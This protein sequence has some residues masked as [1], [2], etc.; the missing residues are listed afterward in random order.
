MMILMSSKRFTGK[1]V[2]NL[3]V[4]TSVFFL[5]I[6][7]GL[8]TGCSKD[9]DDPAVIE[10]AVLIGKTD[11]NDFQENLLNILDNELV[12]GESTTIQ[13]SLA[14]NDGSPY[15]T[16]VEVFFS[17]SCASSAF[18]P[19][20]IVTN[21]GIASVQYT[22]GD[23]GGVDTIN[24][25]STING[26]N[27]VATGGITL[28]RRVNVL[29]DVE[30]PEIH[31]GQYSPVRVS[32]RYNNS[33][34]YTFI[35]DYVISSSC[36]SSTFQ[37]TSSVILDGE[38]SG[39]YTTGNCVGTET[40]SVSV[41]INGIEFTGEDQVNILPAVSI[42]LDVSNPALV[43][44]GSSNITAQLINSD[45]TAYT[46]AIPVSFSTSCPTSN[47]VSPVDTSGGVA[48]TMY[49]AGSCNGVDTISATAIINASVIQATSNITISSP[50]LNLGLGSSSGATFLLG[51]L[52][53]GTGNATA[54][55]PPLSPGG[56]TSVMATIVDMDNANM[57]H[58][59]F[60][61]DVSFS[62]PCVAAGLATITSPISFTGGTAV[63]TY[64][65]NGCTG[66]D[67][68]TASTVV[69]GNVK[70]AQVTITS[71]PQTIGSIQFV[72]ADPETIAT[73]GIGAPLPNTST[74]SFQVFDNM[75]S[76]IA[77]QVVNFALDTNIGGISL[78]SPSGLTDA[79]GIV[80]VALQ[81]GT[82][83]TLVRVT[84][85]T[86]DI[87][88]GIEY[89]TQSDSIVIS[90][91][92]PDQDSFSLLFSTCNPSAWDIDGTTV[93]VTALAT[94]HFNNPVPDGTAVSFRTE[95]GSIES[96]CLTIN[97]GCSVIWTSQNPRPTDGRVTVLATMVG[98]ESFTDLN[99]NG[100]F[101]DGDVWGPS[102]PEAWIDANENGVFDT[103]VEEYL[104]FNLDGEFTPAN[105]GFDGVLCQHS[106]DCSGNTSI[107]VRQSGVINMASVNNVIT[108]DGGA[109]VNSD[110]SLP[111]STDAPLPVLITVQSITGQ[112][113][114]SG[115]T[116]EVESTNG[117]L[118][119]PTSFVVPVHCG[120]VPYEP[121]A[122]TV[123]MN[124][125]GAANTGLFTVTVTT[126]GTVSQQSFNVTDLAE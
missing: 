7:F 119:G 78:A 25:T 27:L 125:D 52:E 8:L 122:T 3:R 44:G 16:P 68:V 32:L 9:N 34:P 99:S 47:I 59:G 98:N 116:V 87:S 113:P 82:I 18:A 12:S 124:G 41:T 19:A 37:F 29:L 81:A 22:A 86:T 67:V 1:L 120:S 20:S 40:V 90:S 101:D 71:A 91:L 15:T 61:G 108:I 42:S 23:C 26:V 95:G 45:Q 105:D 64:V 10:E 72:S 66:D 13:V 48:T 115:T 79:D 5:V 84:A 69:S 11:G 89:S 38:L 57:L 17:A 14:S 31:E 30:R 80:S 70:V 6:C 39:E 123:Y 21:G 112:F 104:D 109:G 118:S 73:A 2:Q 102:L 117:V 62:S 65:S 51:I 111:L 75:G 49:V 74:L 114:A 97:G 100:I 46:V 121:F 50:A 92:Y 88:T 35:T 58:A 60:T 83:F 28:T 93:E 24:A 107:H 36:A 103:G 76:P 106:T 94:D 85:S 43:P 55:Q 63:T 126:N 110:F 56:S 4:F 77:N 54:G 96:S 33:Q 53:A